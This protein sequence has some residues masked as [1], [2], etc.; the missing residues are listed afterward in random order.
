MWQEISVYIVGVL[1]IVYLA[2][3]I[4]LCFFS[5][6]NRNDRCA[7][8]RGCPLNPKER[9]VDTRHAKR[10]TSTLPSVRQTPCPELKTINITR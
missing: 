10:W 5:K 7:N 1:V 6:N 2:R 3:R 9:E 8:C 4:F